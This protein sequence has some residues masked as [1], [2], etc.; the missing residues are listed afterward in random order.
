MSQTLQK[1]AH[2]LA[3]IEQSFNRYTRASTL[4][5]EVALLNVLSQDEAAALQ[6]VVGKVTLGGWQL[7]LQ[8]SAL[9]EEVEALTPPPPK[10][11]APR[12]K[13]GGKG[14]NDTDTKH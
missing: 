13:A 5:R 3:L 1:K 6:T 9:S 12:K 4:L 2:E 8:V 10:K 14:E 11:A 7:G